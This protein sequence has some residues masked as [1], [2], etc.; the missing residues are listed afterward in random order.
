MARNQAIGPQSDERMRG[1]WNTPLDVRG[2][3]A[4]APGVG[5]SENEL[6]F[7]VETD[8]HQ[9]QESTRIRSSDPG[10][11]DGAAGWPEQKAPEHGREGD[12]GGC[13]WSLPSGTRSK[14]SICPA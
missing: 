6:V 8:G 9:A 3:R 4:S 2:R 14:R 7:T 13:E 10:G 12:R 1:G 11:I 5:M